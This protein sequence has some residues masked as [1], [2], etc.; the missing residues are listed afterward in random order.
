MTFVSPEAPL[1]DQLRVI[2]THARL[3]HLWAIHG[4]GA[5]AA[6]YGTPHGRAQTMGMDHGEV[7]RII[8]GTRGFLTGMSDD[9]LACWS[10][11]GEEWDAR[12]ADA[13]DRGKRTTAAGH[14]LI[15]AMCHHIGEMMIYSLGE[16]PGRREAAL[17]CAASFSRVADCF[18][19]PAER[20]DVPFGD[21]RLPGY[22]RLPTGSTRPPVALLTG[23]ANSVKEEL[24]PVTEFLLARGVATVCFEAPGQGEYFA[25]TDQPLRAASFA[26]AVSA[27]IDFLERDERVDSE[28]IAAFGRATSGLLVIR[29]AAVDG[30][31]KAV[32]AH[33]G[34]YDWSAFFE[35]QFPF[36]PSQLELFTVLGAQSID[37]GNA[38]IRSEF[39]LA[40]HLAHVQVPMLLVNSLDDR[41]I[42]A[43][44]A[45]RI[46]ELA[47]TDVEVVLYPG[48]AHGGP[49]A[50]AQP[51]EADWLSDV[52]GAAT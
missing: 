29:A 9:W 46:E 25:R 11:A 41:A 51:L 23:G 7:D 28:R 43:S 21:E 17:R 30:R 36:Y 32:V 27:V 52:L 15:A 22:L 39:T 2:E 1:A 19:P 40:D 18:D 47:K 34:S 35:R 50:L 12:A 26:A 45:R 33:P 8:A 38:L 44:E 5:L 16:V 14:G 6:L 4:I 37:E 10:R 31:I 3:N 24:H 49:P 20:I 13:L 42:P 48:R